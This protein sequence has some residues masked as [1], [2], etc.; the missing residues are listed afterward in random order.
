MKEIMLYRLLCMTL[1]KRS[2]TIHALACQIRPL[3]AREHRARIQDEH[4]FDRFVY[5]I[6]WPAART[7]ATSSADE[8]SL[9]P[10]DPPRGPSR[11]DP[12]YE[13]GTETPPEFL[14]PAHTQCLQRRGRRGLLNARV[15]YRLY[16]GSW[17]VVSCSD[18]S[19]AKAWT[20]SYILG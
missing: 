5:M 7:S 13:N 2:D 15:L 10:D 1:V 18:K 6:R 3:H 4:P 17:K 9:A 12:C 20:Q 8:G 11:G 14:L 16:M 19:L